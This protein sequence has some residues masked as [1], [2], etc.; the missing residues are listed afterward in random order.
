MLSQWKMAVSPPKYNYKGVE[1]TFVDTSVRI[2][3][4]LKCA[5]CLELVEEPL[6]TSCDHL[7]C[8]N[9]IKDQLACPTCRTWFTTSPD[10][11][12]TKVLKAFRVKCPHFEKGCEWEGELGDA[13]EHLDKRCVHQEM[14]CPKGCGEILKG[15]FDGVLEKHFVLCGNFPLPCPAGCRTLIKRK[16]LQKH[17]STKCPEEYVSC[18][19]EM[20]GCNTAVKRRKIEAHSSDDTFHLRKSLDAQLAMF[21]YQMKCFQSSTY[22]PPDLSS[23]PL[24]FRPWLINAP[25]C[26]P[27]P[28]WVIKWDN[29]KQMKSDN[30]FYKSKP[31]FSHFGGY[32]MQIGVFM[33]GARAGEGTHIS[34][35]GNLMKG[36]NDANL[37]FSFEGRIVVSLL[38]QLEDKT[39][40]TFTLWSPGEVP[41]EQRM[42]ATTEENAGWGFPQFIAHDEIGFDA[43]KNC[44]Y[45]KN[46]CIFI[47]VDTFESTF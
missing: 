6:S 41:E 21:K 25:T 42:R 30:K 43:D 28:P 36:D 35:Y 19:Y 23:L 27:C 33:N 34:L 5:I 31:I 24:S 2:L 38:N 3:E 9:C 12:S 26:Y 8:G 14:E 32:K 15:P 13:E 11:S 37:K 46:D 18:K 17:L 4:E 44:Q 45:L 16:Y 22:T 40:Y 29:F 47:R 10:R 7:F 20:F 1:Y 39:H